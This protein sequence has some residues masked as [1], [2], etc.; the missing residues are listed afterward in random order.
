MQVGVVPSF[1]AVESQY[2]AF[3]Y[4]QPDVIA[5]Q[6][7]DGFSRGTLNF[8]T[9]RRARNWLPATMRIWIAGCGTQ[10]ASHW[11]LTHPEAEIVATDLSDTV[12]GIARSVADQLGVENVRFEKQN[13][14]S[15]SFVDEFDL[16]VSTGV[17]HHMPDPVVGATNIRRALRADGAA[18]LM[19]YNKLHRAT[20][21]PFREAHRLLAGD[22]ETDGVRFSLASRLLDA[23]VDSPR[24]EPLA[25]SALEDLRERRDG[26][27]A[28]VADALLHPLEHT[29]DVAGLLDLLAAA[30]LR[31]ASWREPA[32]WDLDHY[33]DDEA[34]L[35]RSETLDEAERWRVVYAM[36]GRAS[37]SLDVIVEPSDGEI[38]APYSFDEILRMRLVRDHGVKG[39]GIE[40]G[41]LTRTGF[42]PPYEVDDE[43][44]RGRARVCDG[45]GRAWEFPLHVR[46]VIEAFDE[47]RAIGDVL[48]AF[49]PRIPRNQLME[50]IGHLLPCDIGVLAPIDIPTECSPTG[51][52]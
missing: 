49:A 5:R 25:R 14:A 6:L 47:P 31:H 7:P 16:V 38:R 50:L 9:R 2:D 8:L 10:Q 34:I 52:R 23:M 30:G 35:A 29:Y 4:P 32:L 39:F 28:F 37:P 27:R 24:C 22:D 21:V 3:P 17:I 11:A 41:R 15:A 48:E 42:V 20:L 51:E 43:H 44:V 36:A 19:V 18:V 1:D 33:T 12:L 46:E 26:D 40:G 13:I 45:P